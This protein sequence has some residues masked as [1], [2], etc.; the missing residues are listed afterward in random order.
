MMIV[1][2]FVE[3]NLAG[4]TE[5]LGETC[6]SAT[7]STTSPTWTDAGSNSGR[8]G[9]KPVTNRLSYGTVEMKSRST[10]RMLSEYIYIA[11]NL[12][13]IQQ[14]SKWALHWFVTKE[15]LELNLKRH[16]LMYMIAS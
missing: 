16:T 9:E 2:Q 13:S 11:L 3:W 1:E 7:L 14:E 10:Q 4:E 5:A 15:S 12:L 8:R 6:L